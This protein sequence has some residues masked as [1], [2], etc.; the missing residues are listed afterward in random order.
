MPIN[1]TII[2]AESNQSY[3]ARAPI[4]IVFNSTIVRDSHFTIE[5]AHEDDFDPMITIE[6]ENGTLTGCVIHL[7]LIIPIPDPIFLI[8][9]DKRERLLRRLDKPIRKEKR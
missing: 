7:N 6:G 1:E 9:T 5:Y 3:T 8:N 2:Q 4:K